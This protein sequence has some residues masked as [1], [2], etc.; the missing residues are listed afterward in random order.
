MR[1]FN[2]HPAD[3]HTR[4]SLSA[5]SHRTSADH[6]TSAPSLPQRPD[7]LQQRRFLCCRRCCRTAAN[8]HGHTPR[9]AD[10]DS[11][12]AKLAEQAN[13]PIN[14]AL[15]SVPS[16]LPGVELS[17]FKLDALGSHAHGYRREACPGRQVPGADP[18]SVRRGVRANAGSVVRARFDYRARTNGVLARD[19]EATRVTRNC[20]RCGVCR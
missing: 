10:F 2:R 14:A 12:N 15:A 19:A 9:P 20:R 11:F 7:I 18:A 17:I 1:I 8:R 13:I 5:A 3:R 6:R 4:H 16:D